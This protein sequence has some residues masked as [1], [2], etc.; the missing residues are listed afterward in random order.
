MY[1]YL[2]EYL[3]VC[4]SSFFVT[5]QNQMPIERN[6]QEK[7][8]WASLMCSSRIKYVALM[9]NS[10]VRE[11]LAFV[12]KN[13]WFININKLFVFRFY[14]VLFCFV[15]CCPFVWMFVCEYWGIW[16]KVLNGEGRVQKNE[17]DLWTLYEIPNA[18][19]IS[20]AWLQIN[21]LKVRDKISQNELANIK[22]E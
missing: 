11:C 8:K 19:N 7:K 13:E 4:L 9:F 14:L 15:L 6:S 20:D 5:E 3:F 21:Y 10:L 12:F 17:I 16:R 2:L 18:C 1:W 22:A